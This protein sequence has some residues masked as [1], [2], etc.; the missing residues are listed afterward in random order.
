MPTSKLK[1]RLERSGDLTKEGKAENN[2]K[3]ASRA[4]RVEK[5]KLGIAPL[6]LAHGAMKWGQDMAH[7]GVFQNLKIRLHGDGIRTHIAGASC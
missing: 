2:G 5:I 1:A 4:M 3:K 6:A 7:Q